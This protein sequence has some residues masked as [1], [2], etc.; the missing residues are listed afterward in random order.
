MILDFFPTSTATHR[1]QLKELAMLLEKYPI[2]NLRFIFRS[3]YVQ[4]YDRPR[5]DE[6]LG[7]LYDHY[8]KAIDIYGWDAFLEKGQGLEFMP[9]TGREESGFQ[10]KAIQEAIFYDLCS[11]FYR[12]DDFICLPKDRYEVQDKLGLQRDRYQMVTV[13]ESF[14]LKHHG[15]VFNE[16]LIFYHPFLRRNFRANFVEITKYIMDLSHLKN[17]TLQVAIDPF[18]LNRKESY[19][20][21]MEADHW[22]GAKFNID[23]LNDPLY[24]GQTI[25]KRIPNDKIFMEYPIDRIEVNVTQDGHLKS[26]AVEELTPPKSILDKDQH[27]FAR[28]RLE[29]SERYRLNKF[30]HFIWDSSTQNFSHLDVAV[31]VHDLQNY[32]QRFAIEFAKKDEVKNVDKIKLVRVDG[33]IPLDVVEN[34]TAYFF[35]E[36]ELI[37]EFFQGK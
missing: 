36:N 34:L 1:A 32:E 37:E 35:R 17:T 6:L 24:V 2:G 9:M 26:F 31:I 18:R 8:S 20:E 27:S 33:L 29:Y 16:H 28:R 25:Y 30:A 19:M 12:V 4:S 3:K 5:F 14:E 22:W 15:I 11:Y 7:A 10:E 13:D 23:R 21:Y